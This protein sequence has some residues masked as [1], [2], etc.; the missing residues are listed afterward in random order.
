MIRQHFEFVRVLL[1][2]MKCKSRDSRG[3]RGGPA[4]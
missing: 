4:S 2:E 3:A 1:K